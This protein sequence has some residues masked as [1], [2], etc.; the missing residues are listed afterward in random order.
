[1]KTSDI[2][3]VCY[4]LDYMQLLDPQGE[5]NKEMENNVRFEKTNNI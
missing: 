3:I 5:L 4:C 1:M 2:R